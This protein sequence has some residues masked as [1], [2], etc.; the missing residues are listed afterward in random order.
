MGGLTGNKRGA[1][2]PPAASRRIGDRV[3]KTYSPHA[4]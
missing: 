4:A 2:S 1:P 3:K